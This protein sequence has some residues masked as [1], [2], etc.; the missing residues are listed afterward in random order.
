MSRIKKLVISSR[1]KQE[2]TKVF[3]TGYLAEKTEDGES[4]R[5][6]AV[7]LIASKHLAEGYRG[8][9]STSN[10][11]LWAAFCHYNDIIIGG[12]FRVDPIKEE[13]IDNRWD[14]DKAPLYQWYAEVP[15]GADLP[16]VDVPN[17]PVWV[18][19]DL[20]LIFGASDRINQIVDAYR[21]AGVTISPAKKKE[22]DS[23]R[24]F[25]KHHH[26]IPGK[27]RESD[28]ATYLTGAS[29]AAAQKSLIQALVGKQIPVLPEWEQVVW[30]TLQAEKLVTQ[31]EGHHMAG[32]KIA[33][34]RE[35]ILDLWG[36]RIRTRTF[37]KPAGLPDG[38]W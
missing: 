18:S 34:P 22:S 16:P 14:C 3:C 25:C 8:E 37:P 29:L 10:R 2:L 11:A 38:I 21:K 4:H 30:D 33:L 9:K 1:E 23:V 6:L 32:Y 26:I 7:D 36:E 12:N 28:T 5:L 17:K 20:T 31:L 19:N 24:V 27:A 35:Q 15:T 13:A